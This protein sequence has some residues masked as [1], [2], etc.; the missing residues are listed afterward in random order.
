MD[1]DPTVRDSCLEGAKNPKTGDRI[2]IKSA[3]FFFFVVLTL[4]PYGFIYRMAVNG[5]WLG[6]QSGQI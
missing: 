4:Y 6:V 2:S 1:L 5:T 3:Y